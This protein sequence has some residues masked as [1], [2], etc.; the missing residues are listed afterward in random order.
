[1]IRI[2]ARTYA[3]TLLAL[4]NNQTGA[5]LES[6]FADFLHLLQKNHDLSQLDN[7]LSLYQQL[8]DTQAGI[9]T[10]KVFYDQIKPS[11][12]QLTS[13]TQFLTQ[14]LAATQINL[15]LIHKNF[16]S[17]LIIEAAG[18][19]YNFSLEHQLENFKDQL[20]AS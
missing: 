20:L 19:Q 6:S 13:I 3:Q 15:N 2:K 14:K 4:T 1:M 11:Q 8:L 7:I 18:R 10:A 5:E 16:G 9:V 17:G 12:A